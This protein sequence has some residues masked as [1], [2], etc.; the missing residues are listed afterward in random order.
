MIQQSRGML[1]LWNAVL[2]ALTF[3]L[4]IF[5][6]YLTR[7]GVIDSVHSFGQSLIGTF[8]LG[9]LVIAASPAS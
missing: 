8:F 2:I 4:C 7:S 6:T 9:F 1:K 3:I 5:G